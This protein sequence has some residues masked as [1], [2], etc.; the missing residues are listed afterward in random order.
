MKPPPL[1]QDETPSIDAVPL[2]D[3]VPSVE[4]FRFEGAC[5][6]TLSLSDQPEN[7][8]FTSLNVLNRQEAIELDHRNAYTSKTDSKKSELLVAISWKGLA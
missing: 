2:I 5:G 8:D 7:Q 6:P 3:V 4:V 1:K